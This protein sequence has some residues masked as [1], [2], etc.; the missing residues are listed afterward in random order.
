MIIVRACMLIRIH[1]RTMIIGPVSAAN[2]AHARTIM[3]AH[4][5]AMIIVRKKY[6]MMIGPSCTMFEVHVSR[7]IE[8]MLDEIDG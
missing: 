2:V 1:A 8:L 7:P 3:I 5:C 6:T 4:A